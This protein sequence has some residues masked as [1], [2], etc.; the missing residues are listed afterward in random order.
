M[1]VELDSDVAQIC[2]DY[3]RGVCSRKKRCKFQHPSLTELNTL[4]VCKEDKKYEFCHD[5]QN[6]TCERSTC[7][8]IHCTR[9]ALQNSL[10][11]VF[12][13]D[14]S[15]LGRTCPLGADVSLSLTVSL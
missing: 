2:R 3:I 12:G 10:N 11:G 6:K 8:Y 7:R 5:H 4:V 14:L 13:R 1:D 9:K 15:I